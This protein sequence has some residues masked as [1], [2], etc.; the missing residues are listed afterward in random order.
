MVM[1]PFEFS[2]SPYF[3][4][5]IRAAQIVDCDPTQEENMSDFAEQLQFITK[6]AQYLAKQFYEAL[7]I[8]PNTE[9]T[10][11]APARFEASFKEFTAAISLLNNYRQSLNRDELLQGIDRGRKAVKT[12]FDIFED[13]RVEE[14]AFPQ[15]SESPYIQELVRVATGVAKQQYPPDTLK[16]KLDWMQERYKEFCNDFQELKNS[17]HESDEVDKLI[18]AAEK[19]LEHMGVG[20]NMM[21]R[22]FR[23]RDRTNL[24]EG[25]AV[26]LQSSERL[27]KVQKRLM[28]VSVAQPAACPKCGVINP[29][30]SKTCKDCGAIMPEIV[31]LS[32]QTIE[33]REQQAGRP[34]YTYLA[35]LE[36]A[37]EGRLQNYL[38]DDELKK[39]IEAFAKRA[40]KGR[41]DFEQI[42]LPDSYPDEETQ[43]LIE[44]AHQLT[45]DGTRKILEGVSLLR[46]Y[47]VSEDRDDLVKGLETIYAGADDITASQEFSQTA[48]LEDDKI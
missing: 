4:D 45:D 42:S 31:G 35:Q 24:K 23:D 20:L 1:D 15:F 22:F 5:V 26:L 21:S 10:K 19:A 39:Q 8:R 17:P 16:S 36:G 38:S 44:R 28:S 47:F 9:L 18:P 25:C 7:K 12:M 48:G 11:K 6:F 32:K 3:N 43:T 33:L 14:E 27:M 37:V 13:M 30:G 41:Q 29:G 34:S 40:E 2:I 46:N